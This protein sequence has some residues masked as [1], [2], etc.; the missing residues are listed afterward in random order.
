MRGSPAKPAPEHPPVSTQYKAHPETAQPKQVSTSRYVKPKVLMGEVAAPRGQL[1]SAQRGAF[2]AFMV[3]HHL[4]PTE[5]A[6]MAGV[7]ASEILAFLTG[8][9]RSFSTG[10]VEKLA[11][12]A[13]VAPE[14][15]FR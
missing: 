10:V 15:L 1:I 7:P 14:D 4:R 13:K 3:A 12:A 6:Q 11:Q 5:W 8:K 2:R 9:A